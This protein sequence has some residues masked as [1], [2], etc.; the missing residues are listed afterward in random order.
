M[1]MAFLVDLASENL[2]GVYKQWTAYYSVAAW[3]LKCFRTGTVSVSLSSTFT[4]NLGTQRVKQGAAS[5]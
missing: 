1:G 5:H 3:M 4:I 2:N